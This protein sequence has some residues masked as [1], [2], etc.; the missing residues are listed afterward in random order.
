MLGRV[1]SQGQGQDQVQGLGLGIGQSCYIA[2][3]NILTT[4]DEF[5]VTS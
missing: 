3:V 2:F 4:E 5:T 1:R